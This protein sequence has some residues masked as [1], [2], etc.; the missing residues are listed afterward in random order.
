MIYKITVETRI[1]GKRKT[2]IHDKEYTEFYFSRARKL[3]VDL[4]KQYLEEYS[5]DEFSSCTIQLV[6]FNDTAYNILYLWKI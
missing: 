1:Y 3:Y 2:Y 6:E 4:V 5:R